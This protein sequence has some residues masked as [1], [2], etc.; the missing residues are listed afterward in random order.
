MPKQNKKG[1]QKGSQKP[2]AKKK[3]KQGQ[4]TRG[5]S[6]G[7]IRR[8]TDTV[9][10]DLGNKAVES[11]NI[12]QGQ[13]PNGVLWDSAKVLSRYLVKRNLSGLSTDLAFEANP[14]I[15]ELGAGTG[16]VALACSALGAT[17][18]ITDRPTACSC[19]V[20]VESGE[21]NSSELLD[22]ISHNINLNRMSGKSAAL[23]LTWG[24]TPQMEQV[25]KKGPYRYI[26]GSDLFYT[27]EAIVPLV[28]TINR[29]SNDDTELAFSYQE[30]Q[31]SAQDIF[32][33][34]ISS[35]YDVKEV[36]QEGLTRVIWCTKKESELTEA[37]TEMGGGQ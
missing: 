10:V 28:E 37:D 9:V 14:K 12:K 15:V 18:V 23:P 2:Y 6:T 24:D 34:Q 5:Y 21:A 11:L 30:R 16:V 29:L 32:I 20:Q 13:W 31:D 27:K 17:T 33:E 3:K 1:K 4:D 25:A 26:I 7:A 22:L 19:N 35:L 8:Q 36:M